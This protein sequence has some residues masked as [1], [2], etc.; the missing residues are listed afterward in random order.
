MRKTILSLSTII[1][2]SGCVHYNEFR[3]EVNLNEDSLQDVVELKKGA[4]YVSERLNF[5]TQKPVYNPPIKLTKD[6]Q[7]VTDLEIRDLNGDGNLDLLFFMNDQ[8]NPE[9]RKMYGN[10]DGTFSVDILVQ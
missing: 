10:G 5:G 3:K 7:K 9:I 6:Y 1:A 8:K 4:I 2:L